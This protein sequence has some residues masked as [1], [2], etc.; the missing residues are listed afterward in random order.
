MVVALLADHLTSQS[1]VGSGGQFTTFY[2]QHSTLVPLFRLPLLRVWQS[3]SSVRPW[4][5]HPILVDI[6]DARVILQQFG[7]SFSNHVRFIN[8]VT[9]LYSAINLASLMCRHMAHK[10]LLVEMAGLEY[11]SSYYHQME[12]VRVC[13]EGWSK[14]RK[15]QVSGSW[16]RLSTGVL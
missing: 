9:A 14:C 1:G 11:G 5:T 8:V 6:P 16:T 7:S 3:D 2:I 10:S 4:D 12:A 15:S 13:G